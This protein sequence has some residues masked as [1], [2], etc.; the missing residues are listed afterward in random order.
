[1]INAKH[2]AKI[3]HAKIRA[4]HALVQMMMYDTMD[5]IRAFQTEIRTVKDIIKAN[6]RKKQRRL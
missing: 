1:M 3:K 2:D 4:D 6:N 5:V